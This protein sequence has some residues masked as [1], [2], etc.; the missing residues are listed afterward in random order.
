[1]LAV[2]DIGNTQMVLGVYEALGLSCCLRLRTQATATSDELGHWMA[3]LL[4]RYGILMGAIE[5]VCVASVVPQLDLA[6]EQACRVYLGQSPLWV[7]KQLKVPMP[8]L[9]DSPEELGADRLVTSYAAFKRFN[10]AVI[11]VDMGTATTLDVINSQGEYLGG[12]IAPGL[13]IAA[14]ALFQAAS[15]LYRVPLESPKNAIGKNTKEHLQSGLILGYAGL[16]DGLIARMQAE[17]M[18]PSQVISTGGLAP[19]MKQ[20]SQ[21]IEIVDSDLILSG[22]CLLYQ[23]Y[24]SGTQDSFGLNRSQC[25]VGDQE[26]AC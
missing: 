22:L 5:A 18:M 14:E 8:L 19:F 4:A 10:S 2:I 16:I 15:K 26:A 20:A 7:K 1:M 17:L 11:V 12:A 13:E 6:M 24:K 9:I 23:E 21:K 3:S 25:I